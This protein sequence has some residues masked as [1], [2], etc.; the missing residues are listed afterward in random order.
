MEIVLAEERQF[1]ETGIH[2]PVDFTHAIA[3]VNYRWKERRNMQQCVSLVRWDTVQSK[4][5]GEVL[6]I[7]RCRLQVGLVSYCSI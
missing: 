3:G 5:S 7:G 4:Y 6:H 1:T 2:N